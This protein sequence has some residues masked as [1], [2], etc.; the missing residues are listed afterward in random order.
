MLDRL[1]TGKVSRVHLGNGEEKE[2][3]QVNTIS[4][5]L[6]VDELSIVDYADYIIREEEGEGG[7]EEKNRAILFPF[8]LRD[9]RVFPSYRHRMDNKRYALAHPYPQNR[10]KATRACERETSTSQ[11]KERGVRV[12]NIMYSQWSIIW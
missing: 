1:P 7:G 2:I 11:R 8:L 3:H 10:G 5:T 6:I 12:V 9:V 4:P